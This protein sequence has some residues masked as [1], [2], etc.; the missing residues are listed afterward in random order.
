[1]SRGWSVGL[2]V[3]AAQTLIDIEK[4]A[5]QRLH[6]AIVLFARALA[7]EVAAAAAADRPLPGTRLTDGR[8]AVDV[9]REPVL[10]Y[11]LPVPDAAELRVTDLIWLAT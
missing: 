4:A 3:R 2:D 8:Y 11:Y 7:I 10:L 9:Y 1:M 6:D 5:G